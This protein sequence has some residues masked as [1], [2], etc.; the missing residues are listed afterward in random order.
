MPL[1]YGYSK[2]TFDENFVE[3]QR[4][5]PRNQ[6]LAASYTIGRQAWRKKHGRAPYPPH[7]RRQKR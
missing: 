4:K 3:L 1:V 6:A 7:L 2:E 5:L